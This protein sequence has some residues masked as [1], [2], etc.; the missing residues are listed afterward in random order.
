MRLAS[1]P[2]LLSLAGPNSPVASQALQTKSPPPGLVLKPL[3]R[4]YMPFDFS[5]ALSPTS[6][7]SRHTGLQGGYSDWLGTFQP[8]ILGTSCSLLL[9]HVASVRTCSLPASGFCSN[10][11]LY[12]TATP[13]A[14]VISDMSYI[15][16]F[17]VYL[18]TLACMTHEQDFCFV[19]SVP[20]PRTTQCIHERG[21]NG[22]HTMRETP[23]WE[24]STESII[25]KG[26][27]PGLEYTS[28]L[29]FLVVS[30]LRLLGKSF[31][32]PLQ[33]GYRTIL[34]LNRMHC[35]L[36]TYPPLTSAIL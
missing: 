22:M 30:S 4:S 23:Y 19:P 32:I 1:R 20:S 33:W 26:C 14:L 16:C 28:P 18:P 15:L 11:I 35:N 31:L 21:I 12:K 6:V 8:R 29:V 34:T 2:W 13:V 10:A 3:T 24:F 17:A 25:Q 9:K 27:F 7:C 5:P 36:F